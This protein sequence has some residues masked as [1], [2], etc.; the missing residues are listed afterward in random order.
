VTNAQFKT[1]RADHD[2]A[3]LLPGC[4]APKADVA[5]ALANR[6]DSPVLCVD[7]E[8]ATAFCRWLSLKEERAYRLPTYDEWQ[9]VALTDWPNWWV[10]RDQAP[11]DERFRWDLVWVSEGELSG[12]RP[13]S[14]AL[15]NPWGFYDML[16]NCRE[17][18]AAQ[19]EED[20][21]KD[22]RER[23]CAGVSWKSRESILDSWKHPIR[24]RTHRLWEDEVTLR[25]I[26]EG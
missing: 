14:E 9:Y 13:R 1:W 20:D 5:P 21:E 10:V 12:P 11:L 19:D 4:Q 7:Y 17:W 2:S 18:V 8:V 23:I 24:L 25:I 26:C 22:M 3:N 6:D 15:P 16:G